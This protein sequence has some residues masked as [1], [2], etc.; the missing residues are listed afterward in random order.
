MGTLLQPVGKSRF[1]DSVI[2]LYKNHYNS[3]SH[4]PTIPEFPSVMC[5][6]YNQTSIQSLLLRGHDAAFIPLKPF[7]QSTLFRLSKHAKT[8]TTPPYVMIPD[9]NQS[10]RLTSFASISFSSNSFLH[11][12]LENKFPSSIQPIK[13]DQMPYDLDHRVAIQI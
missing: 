13:L 10:Y 3:E 12:S 8:M 6:L 11:P 7:I 1:I 4:Q 5:S 2:K 9:V